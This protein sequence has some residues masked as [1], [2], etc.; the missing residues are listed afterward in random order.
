MHEFEWI[1]VLKEAL[2]GGLS[3]PEGIGD[4]GGL[5]PE[6]ARVVVTDTMVEGVHFDRRWSSFE[7]VAWK[8]YASNVSDVLA[9]GAEPREWLLN[10]ALPDD[11]PA[12]DPKPW[13]QGFLAARDAW[14]GG[15]LVGGDTTRS[16]RDVVVTVTFFGE[17]LAEPWLRSAF[18][19]G[20]RLWI[21]GPLGA[22]AAGLYALQTG[23]LDGAQAL[24]EQHRRPVAPANAPPAQGITG[25]MDISDGLVA[26]L[27]HA[28]KASAVRMVLTSLPGREPLENYASSLPLSA[29]ERATLVDAWQL[30]GGEDYVR[31]VSADESPGRTWR[32]IGYVEAGEPSVWDA[33]EGAMS[34]LKNLG[35][36][37]FRER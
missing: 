24:V 37:H 11:A 8:L 16:L 10:V 20:Q 29:R 21:D 2:G 3:A 31:V 34:P 33:R 9:M 27:M 15:A 35:F 32:Q 36:D 25:G 6:R 22:S 12:R 17:L 26:D 28:A 5:L 30:A 19:P 1:D 4:D 7:D 14:G 18:R 13:V 23:H